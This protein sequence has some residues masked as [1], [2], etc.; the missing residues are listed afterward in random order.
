MGWTPRLLTAK[1]PTFD[2]FH[3]K[4]LARSTLALYTR[5][6]VAARL[7][8]GDCPE[9]HLRMEPSHER[10]LSFDRHVCAGHY[11][12]CLRAG[13]GGEQSYPFVPASGWGCCK[14]PTNLSRQPW[15]AGRE[16]NC[17]AGDYAAGPEVHPISNS[18]LAVRSRLPDT[19]TAT[20]PISAWERR[21]N[22]PTQE[23]MI[24]ILE[25]MANRLIM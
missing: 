6:S 25:I 17:A 19:R 13:A 1:I 15:C 5:P 7:C 10:D 3:S 12:I 21:K 24:G 9:L 20:L 2:H 22:C 8:F 14:Q 23:S 18:A 11:A 4:N 16:T